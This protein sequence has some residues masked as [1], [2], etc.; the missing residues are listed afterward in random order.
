MLGPLQTKE[1]PMYALIFICAASLLAS[2]CDRDTA[3][4]AFQAPETQTSAHGCM[5]HGMAY[6]AAS[7][8]IEE[9]SFAKIVCSNR[10]L[11]QKRE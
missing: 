1:A 10:R 3:T 5:H 11:A 6:A 2:D 7:N 8:L 4:H 9:G